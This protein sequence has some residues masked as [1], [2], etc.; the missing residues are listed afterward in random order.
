MGPR[1]LFVVV[2]EVADQISQVLVHV[3]VDRQ[4]GEIFGVAFQREHQQPQGGEGVGVHDSA[5]G[6]ICCARH[7]SSDSTRQRPVV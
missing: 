6:A 7:R 5:R 1:A 2:N 3:A 4:L